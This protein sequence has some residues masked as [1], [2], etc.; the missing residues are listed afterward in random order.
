MTPQTTKSPSRARLLST[1]MRRKADGSIQF[2]Y[3][4]FATVLMVSALSGFLIGLQIGGDLPD[5]MRLW[6][7]AAVGGNLGPLL[8]DIARRTS[9]A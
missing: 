6:L 3:G 2:C 8:V 4:L 1:V 7:A 9:G 5:Q